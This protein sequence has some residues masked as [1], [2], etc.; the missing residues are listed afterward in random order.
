M[1]GTFASI[2]RSFYISF[3]TKTQFCGSTQSRRDPKPG[4]QLSFSRSR[5]LRLLAFPLFLLSLTFG[6]LRRDRRSGRATLGHW[7]FTCLLCWFVVVT[8][9]AV[10]QIETPSAGFIDTAAGDGTNGYSGDG[11]L[12]TNAELSSPDGA[13]VDTAGNI[14]IAD[15]QNCRIRKVTA[16]TGIIS[17]VAGNGTC[18]YSGDGKAATSAEL[19][20][21]SGVAL[22]TAGNLYIAD[23]DNSRI[24]KVTVSTGIISTVA[25]NGTKG[26]SG[27]GGKATSAELQGP[28]GVAV[29]KAGNIYIADSYGDQQPVQ[30][31]QFCCRTA[32]Y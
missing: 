7:L 31:R 28:T 30:P 21:P 10:A 22:D 6:S 16:S 18:G 9:N 12:A 17:T 24:R 25:G 4:L 29:D 15:T 26:F 32:M 3:I 19:F 8:G 23:W 27:D 20:E 5:L 13:A 1:M 14:Y 2:A 11:G